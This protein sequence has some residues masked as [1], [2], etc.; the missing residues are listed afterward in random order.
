MRVL[1]FRTCSWRAVKPVIERTFGVALYVGFQHKKRA[2][3]PGVS[4]SRASHC[5]LHAKRVEDGRC[6][7]AGGLEQRASKDSGEDI[8]LFVH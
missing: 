1:V 2:W 7:R 5:L 3:L 4:V 8:Y 6:S